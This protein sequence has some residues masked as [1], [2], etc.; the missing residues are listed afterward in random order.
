MSTSDETPQPVA[1]GSGGAAA[2]DGGSQN[3]A[4]LAIGAVLSVATVVLIALAIWSFS[5]DHTKRGAAAVI[6]A[7]LT[8]VGAVYVFVWGRKS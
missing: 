6:I 8:L 7:V 3:T 2:P 4:M 1:G 5:I